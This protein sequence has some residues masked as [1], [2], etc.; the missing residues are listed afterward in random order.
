MKLT[1]ER[2]KHNLSTPL[3]R[4]VRFGFQHRPLFLRETLSRGP[5]ERERE[6]VVSLFSAMGRSLRTHERTNG[7][8]TI[9]QLF[10][11][12]DPKYKPSMPE[13]MTA[14]VRKQELREK[15]DVNF[16]GRVSA[17]EGAS[18]FRFFF[19]LFLL[20]AGKLTDVRAILI[21]TGGWKTTTQ[22]SST[23]IAPTRTPRTSPSARWL[24]PRWVGS[25]ATM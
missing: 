5:G 1:C 7:L 10:R 12:N 13:M 21:L 11:R 24:K 23:N 6:E 14:L 3:R 18:F 20:R 17:L 4:G 25:R 15:V 19:L 22:F 9:N 8:M 2:E 16:D